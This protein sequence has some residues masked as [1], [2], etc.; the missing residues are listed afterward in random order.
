MDEKRKG[1]IALKFVKY[2]MHKRGVH[3]TPSFKRELGDIAK[4]IGVPLEELNR[5][6]KELVQESVEKT[7]GK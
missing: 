6:A 5:F 1:E 4:A 2:L 7:F 3:L